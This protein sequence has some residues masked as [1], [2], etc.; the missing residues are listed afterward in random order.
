MQLC[1][2]EGFRLGPEKR[3]QKT[4]E[5][6]GERNRFVYLFR[7]FQN[8]VDGAVATARLLRLPVNQSRFG[9]LPSRVRHTRPGLGGEQQRHSR[10]H[11]HHHGRHW[12]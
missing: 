4:P 8:V 7:E 9:D 1:G 2:W 10:L 12:Q 3:W 6:Q 5:E 11:L